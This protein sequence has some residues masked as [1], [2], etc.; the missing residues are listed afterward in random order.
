MHSSMRAC[1]GLLLVVSATGCAP[2]VY[3]HHHSDVGV[4]IVAGAMAGVAVAE[5]ASRPPPPPEPE[6]R[7][8][9]V[10]YVYGPPPPPLPRSPRDVVADDRELPSFDPV[11]AR[12]ALNAVDVSACRA[13][14]APSGLG[15]ARIVVNPDGRISKVVIDEPAGLP[16]AAAK[17]IGDTIGAATV[18]PFRGSMITMGTTF[19]VP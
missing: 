11:A 5:L 14:G 3:H 8:T 12:A 10:Y 15:H 17:C 18:A 6:P 13:A 2:A 7:V 4:A 19:L 16:S 9:N 1:L